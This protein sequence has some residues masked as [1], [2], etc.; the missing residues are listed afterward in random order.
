MKYYTEPIISE[1]EYQLLAKL[2]K[3]L[4]VPVPECF[5]EMEVRMPDG[6]VTHHHRQRS[7]SWTRNAY[8]H[9]ASQLM[10]KNGDDT[11]FAAG[12]LSIKDTSEVVKYGE[13][14]IGVGAGTGGTPWVSMD[15]VVSD[16]Y[17][18]AAADDTSGIV[19]GSGAG[20]ESFEDFALGTQ[21]A[22]GTGAG[23]L[24]HGA[25]EATTVAYVAGTKTLTATLIRY[26]NNN[27]GSSVDVN[28]VGIYAVGHTGAHSSAHAHWLQ[29]RDK[30]SSTVTVANTGQ[31]KVEYAV[32]LV[33]PS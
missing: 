2:G 24:S 26:F 28:E 6:R 16:G 30:L 4:G 15:T 5:L 32:S 20:A 7:H 14:G 22:N 1:I 11:T 12:K 23:Q 21:I 31:L 19:V 8:N 33:Y 29:S 13:L 3:K 9:M 17:L 10:A 18:A 25:S 27:T